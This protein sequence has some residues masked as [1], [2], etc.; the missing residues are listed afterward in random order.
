MYIVAPLLRSFVRYSFMYMWLYLCSSLVIAVGVWSPVRSLCMY[1]GA[2][3][4]S[5]SVRPL[6]RLFVRCLGMSLCVHYLCSSVFLSVDRSCGLS[7]GSY[8]YI[9]VFLYLC[10]VCS[11]VIYI[12]GSFFL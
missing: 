11:F 1:V 8:V 5:Y 10:G 7:F 2:A 6:V 9:A 4:C 3:L 12:V